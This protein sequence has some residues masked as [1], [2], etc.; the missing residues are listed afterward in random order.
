MNWKVALFVV[1]FVAVGSL[2]AIW[3]SYNVAWVREKVG[4]GSALKVA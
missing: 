4:P 1:G 2:V 3:A